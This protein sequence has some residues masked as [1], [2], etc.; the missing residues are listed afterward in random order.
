[1]DVLRR[2]LCIYTVRFDCSYQEK[3]ELKSKFEQS[4]ESTLRAEE[5]LATTQHKLTSLRAELDKMMAHNNPNQKIQ[6]HMA[7]KRENNDLKKEIDKL[8]LTIK[9]KDNGAPTR[10]VLGV[11]NGDSVVATK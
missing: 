11:R 8:K 10:S 7:I 2:N 3:E 5:E 4:Q 6:L 9:Q 1:M